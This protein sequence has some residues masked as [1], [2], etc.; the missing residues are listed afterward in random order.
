MAASSELI[1]LLE[2]EATAERE[3]V[4]AEARA[5]AESI[6]ADAQREAAELLTGTRARLEAETRSAL[7]KAQST[8][9]LRASSMVLQAKEEQIAGVFKAAEAE[10]GRLAG[11]GQ[12]YPSALRSFVEEAHQGFGGPAVVTVNPADQA[13]VESLARERGWQV[14]V[15]TDPAVQGGV[16]VASPD[17]RFMVTNTM[18][19]RLERARP[20]LAAQVAR[21]LWE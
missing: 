15:R 5:Q 2:R 7:V 1:T 14:T 13:M 20:A 12:R 6:R 9:H 3:K 16:R 18:A 4:L 19:S 8:T 10:L 17:G 21:A 11:D